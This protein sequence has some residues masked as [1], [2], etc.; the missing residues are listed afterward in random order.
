MVL[1]DVFQST[2]PCGLCVI[3]AVLMETNEHILLH[4]GTTFVGESVN[5]SKAIPVSK[6]SLL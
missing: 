2:I 4:C 3:K 1:E 5:I 6:C